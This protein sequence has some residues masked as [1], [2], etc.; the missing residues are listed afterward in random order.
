[1]LDV[2]RAGGAI[3]E[4]G[5]SFGSSAEVVSETGVAFAEGLLDGGVGATAKHFPGLGA[6]EVNTDFGVASIDLPI[7][8]LRNV[9]EAPFGAFASAGGQLVMLSTAIYPALSDRPA[10]FSR[11]IATGELRE[12][13]GF[14]GVSITD[15]LQSAAA[16]AFGGPA[17]VGRAAARAGTDL[18]LF[19][20]YSAAARA[21]AALRSMLRSRPAPRAGF[22]AAAQRVLDL[23][24]RLK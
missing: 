18:L 22:E 20:Q 16:Q 3:S 6:A 11:T 2:G 5:R 12:R 14:G 19:R 15:A 21:G 4:E 17:K 7:Q 1:V 23:R 10:A 24:T 13:V 8:T 9:D